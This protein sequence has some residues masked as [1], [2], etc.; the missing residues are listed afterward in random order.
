MAN[1]SEMLAEL[2]LA[3]SLDLVRLETGEWQ[4]IGA[5][6]LT[7]HRELGQA[8]Q[9]KIPAGGLTE[10]QRQRLQLLF[11]VTD[12]IIAK[13]Y[14]AIAG[15]HRDRLRELAQW[16]ADHSR[17]ITNRAIG[18]NLLTVSVPAETLRA[19]IDDDIVVGMPAREWWA[20]QG[21]SL[22][23]RFQDA[24]RRGVYA[25]ETTDELV[26][27]VMGTK[28][29]N[30]Q[31]GL[32]AVSRREAEALVRTSVQ[33]VA[34]QARYETLQANQKVLRGRQFR[35]TLDARTCPI[36][37][38]RSGMAWD[39]EGRPL[40]ELTTQA[41]PGPPPWHFQCRCSELPIV[42][43]IHEMVSDP[44]IAKTLRDALQRLPTSTQASM[45]G[46]V[47]RDLSYEEWLKTKPEEF[48]RQ[49]LGPARWRLWRGGQLGLQDLVGRLGQ[50]LTL[51]ELKKKVA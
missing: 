49:V 12:K 43:E 45:D 47:P 44:A 6:L 25:G 22:R 7:L 3:H 39:F 16:E 36:C 15:H 17:Q 41:Y 48:Q 9:R 5:M 51:E 29:S 21:G 14:S 50:P 37:R 8:V 10:F 46:Q 13:N 30:Y 42:R 34:N 1:F 27:R 4:K 31:D 18:I 11:A 33:S 35:I 20:R 32:M 24:M 19:L 38:A 40:N 28:A 2:L 23:A 26:R